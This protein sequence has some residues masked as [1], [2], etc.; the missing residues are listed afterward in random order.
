MTRDAGYITS[1]TASI[2][3]DFQNNLT[4]VNM[5][6]DTFTISRFSNTKLKS[7]CF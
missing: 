5:I 2:L 4:D 3:F 1:N 7:G 6:A